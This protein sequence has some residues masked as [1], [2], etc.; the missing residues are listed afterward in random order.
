MCDAITAALLDC[1]DAKYRDF[2][3][4][5]TPSVPPERIIGVRIPQL[6]AMAKTADARQAEQFM[7]ALP[8]VYFEEN[9]LH[10]VL[11]E[12]IKD[13]G[14]CLA[15][16]EEFLPYIDNWATC[17]MCSPKALK[18][19]RDQT[20]SKAL[21][22]TG[23]KHVYTVRFGIKILMQFYMDEWFLPEYAYRVAEIKSDE[24]YVN[25]M[26]AWYFA[27][28]L[29]KQKTFAMSCIESGIVSEAVLKM[30]VRK[31]LDSYR[32]TAEQKARL[33]ELQIK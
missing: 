8:H 7:N 19:R 5:L 12:H 14:R 1:A 25:M 21:E 16:L 31:A 13:Y 30:T 3:I 27:T 6:R 11:I 17:D 29:C 15:R 23:S 4:K 24:Y 18:A 28:L 10:A 2:S 20:A 9:N 32:V 22:W 33:R 26:A